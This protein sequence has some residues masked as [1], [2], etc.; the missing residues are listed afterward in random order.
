MALGPPP[1]VCGIRY[2]SA[3]TNRTNAAM[4]NRLLQ[5]TIGYPSIS[6]AYSGSTPMVE[7][8]SPFAK[9]TTEE[10]LRAAAGMAQSR[11][12][13]PRSAADASRERVRVLRLSGLRTQ[14][15]GGGSGLR[16]DG[17]QGQVPTGGARGESHLT[18]LWRGPA[19]ECPREVRR[20]GCAGFD[21]Q[22][23]GHYLSVE[24]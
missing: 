12:G 11:G 10:D 2:P 21:P 9:A 1:I 8:H 7:Y 4:A 3:T 20:P 22:P 19:A 5:T 15:R 13:P 14:E 23:H 16:G 6:P 24:R 18:A 17:R